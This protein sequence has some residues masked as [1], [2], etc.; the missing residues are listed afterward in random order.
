VKIIQES[1]ERVRYLGF[2]IARL[3]GFEPATRCLEDVT[4]MSREVCHVGQT[5]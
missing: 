5:K 4:Q 3:A 1:G 2:L